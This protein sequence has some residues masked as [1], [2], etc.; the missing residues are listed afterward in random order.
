HENVI[1]VEG[2]QKGIIIEVAM[3]YNDGYNAN[4]YSFTKYKYRH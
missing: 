3:Q 2:E 4:I 1:Y